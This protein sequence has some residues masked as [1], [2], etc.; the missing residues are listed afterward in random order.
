MKFHNQPILIF[1]WNNKI[2]VIDN[3]D[4]QQV[5][6]EL[7]DLADVYFVTNKLKNAPS[8]QRKK[9]VPLFPHYP[10]NSLSV[11]LKVFGINWFKN[12]NFKAVLQQINSLRKRPVYR[13]FNFQKNTGNFVFFVSRLWK[14]EAE[15]NEIRAAFIRTCKNN[16]KIDF[17]GG[18]KERTDGETYG[19]EHEL[20]KQSFSPITFSKHSAKSLLGFNN[21]AV[22]GAVSWR[23]AEYWNHGIFVLSFPFKIDLPKYPEH[24]K[25]QFYIQHTA[26]FQKIINKALDDR[27]WCNS[28]AEGGNSYFSKYCTPTA[29]INYIL[30]EM[31]KVL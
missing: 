2:G 27:S 22:C 31:Q 23:L 26:D 21:P 8:Y 28:I 14:K 10:I 18:F 6:E 24:E 15:T 19:Y 13:K 20:C 12:V 7:Y 5:K 1:R 11:Y 16:V 9:I 17:K 3:D 25:E 30:Q 4:P 29:Q